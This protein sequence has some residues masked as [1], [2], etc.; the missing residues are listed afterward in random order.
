MRP[1]DKLLIAVIRS[2]IA[3]NDMDYFLSHTFLEHCEVLGI[4]PDDVTRGLG[5]VPRELI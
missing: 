3:E 5:D 4:N 2:A 1:I